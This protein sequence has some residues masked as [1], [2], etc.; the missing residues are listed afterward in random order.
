MSDAVGHPVDVVL[1]K[2]LR[3]ELRK[4]VLDGAER[5]F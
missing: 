5:V 3:R 2:G 1:K 4:S